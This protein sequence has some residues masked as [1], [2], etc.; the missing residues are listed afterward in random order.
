MVLVHLHCSRCIQVSCRLLQEMSVRQ[1]SNK[2]SLLYHSLWLCTAGKT[3]VGPPCVFYAFNVV[4]I[5]SHPQEHTTLNGNAL[6]APRC[7]FLCVWN[8]FV[9]LGN[10]DSLA[11]C[12]NGAVWKNWEN[13]WIDICYH[14][15]PK[16]CAE[17]IGSMLANVPGE[18]YHETAQS[19]ILKGWVIDWF[20]LQRL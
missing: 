19:L 12:V 3:T 11:F 8:T 13:K 7:L 14:C 6:T 1:H 2:M 4:A 18:K 5:A 10:N 20:L 17:S 16:P 9:Q 15:I